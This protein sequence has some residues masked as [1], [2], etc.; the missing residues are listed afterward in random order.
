MKK[1]SALYYIFLW[2]YQKNKIPIEKAK[3]IF[4]K[5]KAKYFSI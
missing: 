5:I 3:Q 4:E 1:R 2:D